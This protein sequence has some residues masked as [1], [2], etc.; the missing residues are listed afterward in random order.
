MEHINFNKFFKESFEKLN[1]DKTEVAR[2]FEVTPSIVSRWINNQTTPLPRFQK[3][4][5]R[6]L[7]RRLRRQE[8]IEKNAEA[9]K[10]I[11]EQR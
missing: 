7:E 10:N 11:K 6:W 8:R 9:I 5:I 3:E 2:A 1:L 4:I